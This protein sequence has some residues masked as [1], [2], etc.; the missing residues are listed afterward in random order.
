MKLGPKTVISTPE[1]RVVSLTVQPRQIPFD[2][3]GKR[4]MM[5]DPIFSGLCELRPDIFVPP[6]EAIVEFANCRNDENGVCRFIRKYG[7]ILTVTADGQFG[8]PLEFWRRMQAQFRFAW[9]GFLGLESR[10][11]SAY[12]PLLKETAPQ[13]LAPL[14][15]VQAEGR[16]ELTPQGLHFVAES[17]SGALLLVLIATHERGLLR[18]CPKPGC[19]NPFFIAAHPRQRYCTELCAAWAQ[20]QAKST[21]WKESGK[22]WLKQRSKVGQSEAKPKKGRKTNGT[23]KTR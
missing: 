9:D 18:H 1:M 19:E 3:Q 5:N 22:Q 8:F 13:L 15:S 11:P 20:A 2:I 17:L 23:Q 12:V 14:K 6:V 10:F 21:W 16:F 4:G 7:P